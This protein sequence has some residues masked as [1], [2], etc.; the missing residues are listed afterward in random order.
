MRETT[1]K[2]HTCPIAPS[3]VIRPC[4]ARVPP[5]SAPSTRSASDPVLRFEHSIHTPAP[6]PPLP[7]TS[8]STMAAP[9]RRPPRVPD[10]VHIFLVLLPVRLLS[11]F[12]T[13]VSDCD[14]I[15]NYWEPMHFLQHAFGL[16]TWEYSPSFALRSYTFL[17][18]F[19]AVARL[20]TYLLPT[21][22]PASFYAVRVFL[23]AL[24]AF[25]DAHLHASLSSVFTHA[26]S[27]PFLFAIV[28]SPGIFRASVELLPSTVALHLLTLAFSFWL[29]RRLVHGVF[30]VALAALLAWVFAAA[31]AVPLALYILLSPRG[32]VRFLSAAL[33]AA[34]IILAVMVPID[35]YLFGKIVI[36]PLNHLLYN[37]FPPPGAGSH[38]FGVD[39]VQFYPVNLILNFNIA[40]L[41]FAAFPAV[42]FLALLTRVYTIRD[43][44]VARRVTFLIAPFLY[45]AVLGAQP[46]KEERFIVPAYTMI[47]M[48]AAVTFVDLQSILDRLARPLP[49]S[50]A[51]AG[52]AIICTVL[53]LLCV[54]LGVSRTAMQTRA[55]GA[56]VFVYNHLSEVELQHGAGPRGAPEGFMSAERV[57]N[58][59]VG[60]EWYR[61]P[62]SYF[63]PDNR[64]RIRF[65]RAGFTGLLPKPYDEGGNGT[66]FIPTGMNAYNK[67]DPNQFYDWR[68]EEG[69]HYL[70]DLDLSHRRDKG[71]RKGEQ[72][73]LSPISGDAK[74]VVYSEPFLDTEK[75]SPGFRAFYIPGFEHKLVFGQYQ[76]IRNLD[77]VPIT[78]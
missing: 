50:L 56:P 70:I 38:I 35:S 16:Q 61:F 5:V 42:L 65:V 34:V 15:F 46:H 40:A 21:S 52:K 19:L 48:V 44:H 41:L 60:K 27:A 67:E 69:C 75:S 36:A 72:N 4:P 43:V 9:E 26:V 31:L 6:A 24:S 78:D 66:Q 3:P 64:F 76:I 29:R 23:A 71:D 14:E 18:P 49:H 63:L 30:L 11:A 58:V 45:I 77:L 62:G 57:V 13:P 33:P 55:F 7:P 22:K 53:A 73:H 2:N 1:E 20:P 10:L 28:F 47:A 39:G 54:V 12:V 25:A 37:V 68:S 32:I 74:A 59:C 17:L 8:P 51:R